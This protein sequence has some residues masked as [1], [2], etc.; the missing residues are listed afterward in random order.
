MSVNFEDELYPFDAQL[1]LNF[2]A[3]L[4]TVSGNV[5]RSSLAASLLYTCLSL[6]SWSINLALGY[7]SM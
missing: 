7:C 3:Y 4:R 5:C 6:F 1:T 2:L